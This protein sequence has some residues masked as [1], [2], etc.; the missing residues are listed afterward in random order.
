MIDAHAHA[1]GKLLTC[2][3]V[4][5]YLEQ[6][7]IEKMILCGGEPGSRR[8]YPYPLL[9][10][11]MREEQ[12]VGIING[13]IK[14]VI[15]KAGYAGRFDEEN[16]R[17]WELSRQLPGKVYAAYWVNPLE[18]DCLEKM[19]GFYRKKGFVMIKLHQCWT[20]FDVQGERCAQL[21]EWAAEHKVPVFIHLSDR[22][23]AVRF[24]AVAE[25]FSTTRFIVAHML[26]AGVMAGGLK[27]GNVYFDLSSP[28]L[29]SMA[30]LRRV[31]DLWGAGHMIMG[32][33]FPY[34]LQNIRHVMVRLDN[35][36]ISAEEKQM[37]CEDN[38]IRLLSWEIKDRKE[39]GI[40]KQ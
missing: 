8:N 5:A 34:G 26:W 10:N 29:Y 18:R 38:V 24:L 22:R 16:E 37:I 21:F 7:G 15:Q 30:T 33:D 25:H 19:D 23:Q 9:S 27:T 28:Q 2:E 32:S 6:N 14:K 35:M 11:I 36:G 4:K 3:G 20:E 40:E 39:N 12:A 31:L 17:V 13:M 1:C